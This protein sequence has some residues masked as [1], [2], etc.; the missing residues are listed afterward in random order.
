MAG[1]EARRTHYSLQGTKIDAKIIERRQELYMWTLIGLVLGMRPTW[2]ES[3]V[4][5]E[6]S[7]VDV[8]F[9]GDRGPAIRVR[10]VAD[11]VAIPACRGIAWE[12]YDEPTGGYVLLSQEPCGSMEPAIW[13]DSNGLD[14]EAPLSLRVAPGDRLR[15]SV[16]I[17]MGCREGEPLQ[18]ASCT[19]ITETSP[20]L[21]VA[22]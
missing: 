22:R 21:G 15:V 13:V 20:T 6:E 14:F 16:V 7:P 18:L 10:A 19:E 2:A 17:G 8:T 1:D 11:P 4:T 5:V 12:R 3:P 9:F